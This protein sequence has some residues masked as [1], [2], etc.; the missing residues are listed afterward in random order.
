LNNSG[1]N[2]IGAS[3]PID[4]SYADGVFYIFK[5][6]IDET[7]STY[8]SR[9]YTDL[10][11]ELQADGTYTVELETYAISPN[12]Y[13]YVGKKP[14]DYII[15]ADTSSSMSSTGSTGI[16]T[17]DGSLAVSSLSVEA[18]TSD[19]NGT[20]VSGYAF[21]NADE[22]I[23]LKHTDG[24][25]YKVYMAVNT[26][27]LNKI[28]GIISSMRQKYYVYYVADDGLYYC[29]ED[30]AVNPVGRTYEEWKAWVDSGENE[31]DYSTKTSNSNRRKEDVYVG[32][33]YRFDD[34]NSA[35]TDEHTRIETLRSA[36]SNLVGQIAAENSENRIA[37][38]QF[39]GSTGFYNTSS[40]LSTTDY[41]NAFWS[42]SNASGLQSVI[43][44]LTTSE[45]TT[46]DGIEFTYVNNILTNSGIDYTGADS[47]RN[48]AVIYLSDGVAG[49][50]SQSATTAAADNIIAKAF[51]AKKLGAFVYTVMIGADGTT[52]NRNLF[53]EA[54]SSKYAE[55]VSMTNLGGQSVDG[56]NYALNLATT[57]INNFINFGDVALE[58]VSS[59]NGVGLENL[60]ANSYLREQLSEAFKFPENT[61]DYA[62][63]VELVPGVFDKI[64]RFAFD[65]KSATTDHSV[66]HTLDTANRTVTVT[67]YNYAEQYIGKNRTTPGNKLRITI[68]G[69]LANEKADIQNTSINDISTTGIYKNE[70]A[71]KNNVAF[72]KLPTSYFNIPEY[73]YVLDYDLP[74][75]D[76]DVN[77]T[78]K[79]VDGAPAKQSTYKT[80]R[81]TDDIKLTF[82]NNNQD[83]TY[84]LNSGVYN[85]TDNT[86]YCLIQREDGTYDWFKLNIVPA[87]NVLYEETRFNSIPKDDAAAWT[88]SGSPLKTYQSLSNE[89]DRY[90]YDK[91]FENNGLGNSNGTVKT[92]TVNS[93]TKRS[94]TLTFSYTGTGFDLMAAC[95]QNT[96]MQIVKITK[97]EGTTKT[98]VK[99]L[100]VD[101]YYN[102]TLLNQVP[103]ARYEGDYGTYD[104]EVT[105]AYLSTAQGVTGS[106]AVSTN[107]L[108]GGV[109]KNFSTKAEGYSVQGIL[110]ELDID[111]PA[112]EVELTWFDDNSVLNGGTGPACAGSKARSTSAQADI[113]L[114]CYV[115]GIRVYNPLGADSS[116][117]IES[118]KNALYFNVI[119][120][121]AKVNDGAITGE[122]A[123]AAYVT[124]E[125]EP[126]AD[127]KIPDLSYANYQSVG[128][129][130]EVYLENATDKSHAVSFKVNVPN[131]SS[132]VMI[133]L[134]A[135][136]GSTTAKINDIDFAINTAT[137]QYFDITPYLTV[138]AN[139][140]AVVTIT[141]IGT[142]ILSVN[143][144]KLVGAA[145]SPLSDMDLPVLSESFAAESRTVDPNA[146]NYNAPAVIEDDSATDAP[147]TD[148]SMQITS[149]IEMLIEIIYSLIAKFF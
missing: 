113:D 67:N 54:V 108:L 34:V 125:L 74:M 144:L 31:S 46:N 141:N 96:G 82:V 63:K 25:Y 147:A 146:Y 133:S 134:R 5:R 28:V 139:G 72:K 48:V 89:N 56:V 127:G 40:S 60:D 105:A 142:G 42:T 102:G 41:A 104:V 36:A 58:E 71:M 99:A 55:A 148:D 50:D 53:M 9:V 83:M 3:V 87:S 45:L 122:G 13:Q 38:V 114:T 64:G 14:T 93:N 51:T 92:T 4:N 135:V 137:E 90:G 47:K 128:P 132:R 126:D 10:D 115:D 15:V 77:G 70:A 66:T 76:A 16:A 80:E 85:E 109:I 140:D 23:Y 124:G 138:D 1:N 123:F 101:T 12:H 21:S 69:L 24:K 75:Y 116:Q 130:H 49:A 65:E 97:V 17:F 94:E 39:G 7:A 106:R 57:N 117:Y 129:Q 22:E 30:H 33:H 37:L 79:S 103:I 62:V 95:G 26:T 110:D 121:L 112:D 120:E 44:N 107:S 136:N 8:E 84:E 52:F 59:N 18:N 88:S 131:E 35:F 119:D 68:S 91:D 61:A 27:E 98:P 2:I 78:L 118:E 143:N 86:S 19:D 32:L 81:S 29:V 11:A 73:I 100:I 145:V 111:I 43:S 20:G 149:L 6:V